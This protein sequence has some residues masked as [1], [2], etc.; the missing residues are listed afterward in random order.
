MMTL[1]RVM[2]GYAVFERMHGM[3]VHPVETISVVQTILPS[4]PDLPRSELCLPFQFLL[5]IYP[6]RP[7]RF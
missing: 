2:G 6:T 3:M 4:V 1:A 5:V 7:N